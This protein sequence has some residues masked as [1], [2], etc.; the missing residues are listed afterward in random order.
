LRGADDRQWPPIDVSVEHRP[1]CVEAGVEGLKIGGGRPV[2]EPR[3]GVKQGTLHGRAIFDAAL[4]NVA[5]AAGFARGRI[6][7]KGNGGISSADDVMAMLRAGATCIDLYSA[8]I[9]QGWCVARD[10]N[11][12][13]APLLG[14]PTVGAQAG[15]GAI[16]QIEA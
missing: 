7:I 9:Y 6:A 8:F 12:E 1:R 16:Q 10:I 14:R 5:R 15:K 3:F 13:L 11:R 2:A 4:E